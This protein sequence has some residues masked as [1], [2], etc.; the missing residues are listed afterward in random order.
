MDY[1]YVIVISLQLESI[2]SY[3]YTIKQRA[4]LWALEEDDDDDFVL[5]DGW[6]LMISCE[7]GIEPLLKLD[8]V[9]LHALDIASRMLQLL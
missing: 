1:I 5:V 3:D 2:V 9:L 4:I 7:V 8:G 6:M